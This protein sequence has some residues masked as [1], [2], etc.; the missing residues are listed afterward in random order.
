MNTQLDT[1][2]H[3]LSVAEINQ[4]IIDQFLTPEYK[5]SYTVTD[6]DLIHFAYCILKKAILR[7]A[8]EK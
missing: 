4:I 7:K 1:Q 6:N 3:L 2:L 8:Q 5:G